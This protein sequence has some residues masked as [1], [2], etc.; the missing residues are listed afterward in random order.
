MW[1]PCD[2]SC[3]KEHAGPFSLAGLTHDAKKLQVEKRRRQV[4]TARGNWGPEHQHSDLD[5]I[6]YDPPGVTVIRT[7]CDGPSAT[8]AASPRCFVS[9]QAPKKVSHSA[10]KKAPVEVASHAKDPRGWLIAP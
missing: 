6:G 5:L 10:P 3:I 4:S 2:L 1:S 9:A 8:V 7:I